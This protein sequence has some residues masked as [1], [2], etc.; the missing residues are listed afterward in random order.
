MK[1]EALKAR[2]IQC[3]KCW[4]FG[5]LKSACQSLVDRGYT[6]FKC[7]MMGHPAKLCPNDMQCAKR[8]VK[9]PIIVWNQRIA[10]RLRIRLN[11]LIVQNRKIAVEH[12]ARGW[13]MTIWMLY[14]ILQSNINHSWGAQ[15]LLM[16]TILARCIDLCVVE[17]PVIVPLSPKWFDSHTKRVGIYISTNSTTKVRYQLIRAGTHYVA[18]EYGILCIVACYLP[19][20]SY[21][22]YMVAL[23]EINQVIAD[24]GKK[25]IVCED[26]NARSLTWDSKLT[27][28]RG[29]L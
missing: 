20:I 26:F 12:P 6:C 9:T 15:D 2:P 19:S 3:Y 11:L 27:N 24:R 8:W 21:N 18:V 13:I 14:K 28:Y 23:D 7:G 17:E 1:V 25:V 29:E 5:H 10:M 22:D 4:A 16:H